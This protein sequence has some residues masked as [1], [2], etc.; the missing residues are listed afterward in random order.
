VLATAQATPGFWD[1]SLDPPLVL[2]IDLA[3]LYWLGAR[4]TVTPKRK[5][6][7]QRWRTACFYGALFVLAI[8]LASPIEILSE[9]LFWVHMVQH[10]LL[11]V[12]AA[13]L[14]V[15]ARPWVRLW[16][17][18]PL[19]WRRWLAHNL[20]QGQR[21]AWLRALSH[22][23]GTPVAGFVCFSVVLL[24]WHVPAL[25]DATLR[26]SALHALEHTLFFLTAV[27]FFKQ[28]IPSPP[29][30]IALEPAQRVVFAI[31]GMIVSWVLAVVLALAPHPLYGIYAHQ[32][33]RPGGIS[34]L[35]DQQLAAGIMWVPGSVTFLIVVFVYVHRWL[36]PSSPSPARSGRLASEH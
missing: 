6:G 12:V 7:E 21:T 9:Q 33:S 11:I 28:A 2:V 1:W 27:M 3:I 20:S 30:R 26:H 10:V 18:L 35:A 5:R 25:F 34:A 19:Q 17:S 4:R 16:R 31:G 13:P 23:L 29:L 8:A 36:M 22:A 24:G 15:V 32:A 14:I